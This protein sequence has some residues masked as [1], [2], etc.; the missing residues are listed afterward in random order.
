MSSVAYKVRIDLSGG[1]GHRGTKISYQEGTG[2][3]AILWSSGGHGHMYS[4][5]YYLDN[6]YPT[7]NTIEFKY[8]KREGGIGGAFNATTAYADG[9]KGGDGVEIQ[10][11]GNV[12][13]VA[14]GGG[15]GGG[16]TRY[17]LSSDPG[18]GGTTHHTDTHPRRGDTGNYYYIRGGNGEAA[19]EITDPGGYGGTESSGGSFGGV[20]EGQAQNGYG[21]G[22]DGSRGTGGKGGNGFY[23][24]GGG[25]G[26]GYY[27]G[28]GGSSGRWSG[29]GGGAGS[30]YLLNTTTGTGNGLKYV[31]GSMDGYGQGNTSTGVSIRITIYRSTDSGS[32]WSSYGNSFSTTNPPTTL[33]T[34]TMTLNAATP[35]F[36]AITP[37]SVGI[38]S[39]QSYTWD[40]TFQSGTYDGDEQYSIFQSPANT[41][42]AFTSTN[43]SAPITTGGVT[44][45]TVT[46]YVSTR[47]LTFDGSG[48]EHDN[49]TSSF[50][51]WVKD[52][53]TSSGYGN[54]STRVTV[55][56][57]K[58]LFKHEISKSFTGT[59]ANTGLITSSG[60]D[61]SN[62]FQ[63][64]SFLD[65]PPTA[66]NIGKFLNS[67]STPTVD[68]SNIF[69]EYKSN[70]S[71]NS[72]ISTDTGFQIGGTDIRHIY[73]ER[74][75]SLDIF[76]T[77]PGRKNYRFS[78]TEN[79][80][81][82]IIVV[83]GGGA[84]NHGSQGGQGGH[85]GKIILHETTLIPGD[86]DLSF[87]VG[88]GEDK[89]SSAAVTRRGGDSSITG[90]SNGGTIINYDTFVGGLTPRVN[91]NNGGERSND[92]QN[93]GFQLEYPDGVTYDIGGG[94]GGGR[95][96]EKTRF[97]TITN[98]K[99]RGIGY[100]G[101]QNG[102]TLNTS[103][104]RNSNYGGGGG[105]GFKRNNTSIRTD[106]GSGGH[107]LCAILFK[108]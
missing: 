22:S 39:D 43:H 21:P 19:Q 62:L 61:I 18:Q 103:T 15:G 96:D 52:A 32:T 71:G 67:S 93:G 42:S 38:L 104:S 106:G 72:I 48:L 102:Y 107:G 95:E 65:F 59:I 35:I 34:Q 23:A 12:L 45:G 25:G 37:T 4:V 84:G 70:Y 55:T 2:D 46:Y 85:G 54:A 69:G 40:L 8:L 99:E 82:L 5:E 17:S 86:Y 75:P 105:G 77:S 101:G 41:Y 24:A 81:V 49:V 98:V 58:R 83:G 57:H 108:P 28:G 31:T 1:A 27:G 29:A 14:G 10:Y 88:A 6:P 94:G 90:T 66:T 26:G 92:A 89:N 11:D 7:S 56:Q 44:R 33:T 53:I 73:A 13:A 63:P 68:Y 20:N 80:D 3:I 74:Q 9:G 78:L 30:S 97:N 60:V 76:D 16:G 51:V 91:N 47:K 50:Q 100:Y 64:K 79:T 36:N 87:N